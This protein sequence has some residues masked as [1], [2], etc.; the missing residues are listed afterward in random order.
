MRSKD[1]RKSRSRSTSLEE[2]A[3][4][5]PA[6]PGEKPLFPPGEKPSLAGFERLVR[7]K[8]SEIDMLV[9]MNEQLRLSLSRRGTRIRAAGIAAAPPRSAVAAVIAAAAAAPRSSH[10]SGAVAAPRRRRDRL[11]GAVPSPRRGG[12]AIV[13]PKRCRRLAA[14][15]PRPRLTEAVPSPRRGGAAASSRRVRLGHR[16]ETPRHRS[17]DKLERELGD[18]ADALAK[19]D[20]QLRQA[21]LTIDDRDHELKQLGVV[22]SQSEGKDEAMKLAATQNREI[23]RILQEANV[24]A[25]RLEKENAEL[26]AEL[27]RCNHFNDRRM[28]RSTAQN[29]RLRLALKGAQSEITARRPSGIECPLGRALPSRRRHRRATP[30]K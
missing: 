21:Q 20:R 2:S 25:Q 28:R 16:S 7:A 23:L 29:E 5:P 26:R 24:K 27:Q 9:T 4:A 6:P 13:S 17:M 10:R 12:A 1:S 18:L 19:K 22:K 14:A 15:A 3:P 11:T 8:Q 30:R